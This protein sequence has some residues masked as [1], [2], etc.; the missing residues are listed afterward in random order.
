MYSASTLYSLYEEKF[1]SN[2]F[3]SSPTGLYAPVN[4]IMSI[5]GKRI[6]PL[7]LLMSTDMFGG[8]VQQALNPSFAMEVF[9]NFTLVH[10]DIMDN[11]DIRRGVPTVHKIF[12]TNAGILAGD[13]M[14]AYA[15]KY[16]TDV[17]VKFI[18]SL[19]SVFTKTAIE[20]FEG[21]QMDIDFEKRSD[22]SLEEYLKMIEYKTS[23]LLACCLQIGAIL[24]NA[25]EK[26]QND[27]Y[28][29]G[30]N[31]GLSFQI[32]DDLLDAFGEGEKVGKKIGG[33]ILM[34]KKTYLF[35]S[36]QNM[37]NVEQKKELAAL[38]NETN[39][40]EKIN[41]IKRLM[42][43]TGAYD[44]TLEKAEALYRE[45]LASLEKVNVSPERKKQ[46]FEMA[47]K[48]NNREY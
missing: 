34:N 15:Y 39:E 8:E 14:L 35:I 36:T 13:V 31:L 43:E 47:E 32:K 20:I 42:K 4:H 7:L 24:G 11:A 22:V 12:G 26:A 45:S 33:D 29:F 1:S 3:N 18:P 40:D 28:N 44:A 41:G 30:L 38:L 2:N 37:A 6:R 10:D 25:D 27:V 17:P 46:L 48:V 9:H 21:Q 16:L 5:K 23:V 19:M